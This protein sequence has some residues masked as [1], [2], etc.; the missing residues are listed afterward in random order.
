[1][2]A[3]AEGVT[4]ETCPGE[5][6]SSTCGTTSATK[7]T[8]TAR[9][10]VGVL[11]S[12]VEAPAMGVEPRR[13]T[14]S[15]VRRDG[16]RWLRKEIRRQEEILIHPDYGSRPKSADRTGLGEPNMGNPSVRFDEGRSGSAGL[17][18][19]VSLIPPPSTS[20]TLLF[21]SWLDHELPS[22]PSFP[23]FP[24]KPC[25]WRRESGSRQ[26]LRE[27][28]LGVAWARLGLDFIS[29]ACYTSSISKPGCP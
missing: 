26:P 11:R 10:G 22:Q 3:R 25:K 18:T 21:F 20:P 15:G 24:G 27:L 8:D 16:G 6:Q 7:K 29:R 12:S 14:C 9:A 13:D 19:A 28:A 5:E 2:S 4:R 17:T 23:A 1:M